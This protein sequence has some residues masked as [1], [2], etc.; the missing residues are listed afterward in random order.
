MTSDR[1]TNPEKNV[2][3][4]DSKGARVRTPFERQRHAL[5]IDSAL[6]EEVDPAPLIQYL[7]CKINSL[8]QNG[9]K[10]WGLG[11]DLVRKDRRPLEETRLVELQNL[12]SG[13]ARTRSKV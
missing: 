11:V 1:W 8:V 12:T 5:L 3:G 2:L 10:G 7:E 4:G 9:G 6:G 13:A